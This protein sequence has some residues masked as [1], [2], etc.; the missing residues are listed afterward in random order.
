M[1]QKAR[2]AASVALLV[3]GGFSITAGAQQYRTEIGYPT[4]SLGLA[5]IQDGDLAKAEAQLNGMKGV[6]ASDPAR[7]INLGHVYARTG[8]YD[9]AVKAYKAA[10]KSEESF[11]VILRDGREMS[12]HEAARLA[13]MELRGAY[14]SR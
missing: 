4:G 9:E 10:M 7:L 2:W 1:N 3:L 14:A 13:L 5:A 6:E 12:T 11:D 8:R